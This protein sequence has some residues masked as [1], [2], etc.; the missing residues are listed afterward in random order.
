MS[1][2]LIYVY[3]FTY[4]TQLNSNSHLRSFLAKELLVNH[5]VVHFQH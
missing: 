2:Q 1:Q 3:E 4:Q 5:L